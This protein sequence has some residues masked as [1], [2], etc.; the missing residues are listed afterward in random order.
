[1]VFLRGLEDSPKFCAWKFKWNALKMVSMDLWQPEIWPILFFVFW[2][3]GGSSLFYPQGLLTSGRA[4][5]PWGA[6]ACETKLTPLK[7]LSPWG[8]SPHELLKTN[9][10]Y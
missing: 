7:P 2:L 3:V 1:M 10:R 5:H 4:A 9:T 8:L 6:A